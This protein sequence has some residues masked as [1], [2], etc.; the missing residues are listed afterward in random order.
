MRGL[1]ITFEGT[2]ATGK[3]VQVQRLIPWLQERGYTVCSLREPGG[4]PTGEELRHVLKHQPNC[5]GMD[6]VTE[7]LIM[8]AS[9]AE[10]VRKIIR[11]SLDNGEIVLCDRF[12]DST[13]AYQGYGR[14]LDLSLVQR[15]VDAAV[16]ETKPDLTFL[17][18]IPVEVSEERRRRRNATRPFTFDRFEAAEREFFLRVQEGYDEIAAR[19]PERFRVIDGTRTPEE[20]QAQI[21]QHLVAL[22]DG[23][24]PQAFKETVLAGVPITIEPLDGS[25]LE[26]CCMC[27]RPTPCWT[28][29]QLLA[30]CPRCAAV[31]RPIDLP[32]PEQWHTRERVA[33]E[34]EQPL[35]SSET[36]GGCPKRCGSAQ[37]SN[38]DDQARL[39][40][41]AR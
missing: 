23:G 37:T 11:P 6:P 36:S 28:Q 10:L 25:I 40:T 17:L 22:M 38:A 33:M 1:L 41:T 19:E 26:R 8:N 21:R 34:G 2:E 39:A 7:L 14:G 20:V 4:T 5:E 12:Y 31:A 35:M 15:V 27:R 30:L 13:C 24:P 18:R 3:G 9:R 16:G 32:T 29:D